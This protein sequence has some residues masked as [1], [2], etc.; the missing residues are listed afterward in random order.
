MDDHHGYPDRGHIADGQS[1]HRAKLD[2]PAVHILVR[3]WGVR[4]RRNDQAT[5]DDNP[6]GDADPGADRCTRGHRDNHPHAGH[7]IDQYDAASTHTHT[8]A[9]RSDHHDRQTIP[10]AVSDSET[11]AKPDSK[12]DAASDCDPHANRHTNPDGYRAF[13]DCDSDG[14]TA[15]DCDS[16][17]VPDTN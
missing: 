1:F 12:A 6:F 4:S 11:D 3:R 7:L 2:Q 9:D 5:Y 17:P 13:T 10:N 8:G 14:N 16:D 15:T